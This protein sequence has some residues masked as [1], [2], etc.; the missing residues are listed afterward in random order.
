MPMLREVSHPF[1]RSLAAAI[2]AALVL[3]GCG[4]ELAGTD[5]GTDGQPPSGE[6]RLVEGQGPDGEI[7]LV[8]DAPVTLVIDG[9]DWRGTAACNH[10]RATVVVDG[11][12]LSVRELIHTEIG[13]PD[14]TVMRSERAYLEAFRLIDRY[15]H[16]GDRL[17]L[18]DDDVELVFVEVAP[19][20]GADLVGSASL[21]EGTRDG[22][23]LG[24]RTR[25]PGRPAAA[26]CPCGRAPVRAA[27]YGRA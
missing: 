27:T 7:P 8:D 3:A 16:D 25:Q 12:D 4:G 1:R 23:A 15:E 10:H 24:H 26:G 14:E 19:D 18:R 13:C 20:A 2:L 22:R 11:R 21:A 6:H 9:E 17:I 5:T